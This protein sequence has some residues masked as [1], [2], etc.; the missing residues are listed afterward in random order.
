MPTLATLPLALFAPA[1]ACRAAPPAE[2]ML[3]SA[4]LP[5]DTQAAG[6][7]PA[8]LYR[9][10]QFARQ[11]LPVNAATL[12]ASLVQQAQEM[13]L[14][15]A[16]TYCSGLVDRAVGGISLRLI[17]PQDHTPSL[18][19]SLLLAAVTAM[20]SSQQVCKAALGQ[21]S[22]QAIAL[23]AGLPSASANAHLAD[24]ETAES[25]STAPALYTHCADPWSGCTPPESCALADADFGWPAPDHALLP[26]ESIPVEASDSVYLVGDWDTSSFTA[27]L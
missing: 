3:A 8:L 5:A 1:M 22:V 4:T 26:V 17:D 13:A 2:A 25:A 18:G 7:L 9:G 11:E 14:N 27:L 23:L 16:A 24:S 15:Q 21:L 12:G 20:P 6:W 10:W 19:K